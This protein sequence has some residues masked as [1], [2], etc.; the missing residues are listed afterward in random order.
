MLRAL[1]PSSMT[2]RAA[3]STARDKNAVPRA[4]AAR[5]SAHGARH[6]ARTST[7]SLGPLLHGN[8]GALQ[9]LR[10]A[11]AADPLHGRTERPRSDD[12]TRGV[13]LRHLHDGGVRA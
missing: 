13:D 4:G 7:R 3:V 10:H 8:V 12:A 2:A 6:L 5:L 11:L 9:L 1:H